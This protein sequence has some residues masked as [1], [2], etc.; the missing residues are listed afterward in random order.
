MENWKNFVTE[1]EDTDGDGLSDSGEL[2][3]VDPQDPKSLILQL[4]AVRVQELMKGEKM[5]TR[6]QDLN[7]LPPFDDETLQDLARPEFKGVIDKHIDEIAH[8]VKQFMV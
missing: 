2:A 3:A 4:I 7:N 8:Y 6:V 1:E 5:M